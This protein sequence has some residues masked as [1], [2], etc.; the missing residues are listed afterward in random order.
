M[1]EAT[2]LKITYFTI[3][4]S[5]LPPNSLRS[6]FNLMFW[7]AIWCREIPTNIHQKTT[8]L[9]RKIWLFFEVYIDKPARLT[10][11][12][13]RIKTPFCQKV[14]MGAIFDNAALFH[15]QYAVHLRDG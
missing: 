14:C 12:K 11:P 15:H 9:F 10:I 2:A 4:S 6:G 7:Q 1:I 13:P 5:A 8:N 3:T